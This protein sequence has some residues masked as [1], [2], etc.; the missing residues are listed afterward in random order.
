MLDSWLKVKTNDGEI[1]CVENVKGSRAPEIARGYNQG[2]PMIDD[3]EDDD[4]DKLT[5]TAK[6]SKQ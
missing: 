6:K 3:S 1:T 2:S 5:L 4:D